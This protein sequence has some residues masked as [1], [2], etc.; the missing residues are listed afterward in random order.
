MIEWFFYK[1]VSCNWN[2]LSEL[3]ALALWF[4]GNYLDAIYYQ[5]SKDLPPISDVPCKIPFSRNRRCLTTEF[6]TEKKAAKYP[7]YAFS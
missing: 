6:E 7:T 4:S 2:T 3:Y 1:Y 5:F